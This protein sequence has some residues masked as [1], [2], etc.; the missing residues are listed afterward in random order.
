MNNKVKIFLIIISFFV[1]FIILGE[2]FGERER[3][4]LLSG[5]ILGFFLC[6]AIFTD[7]LFGLPSEVK[8]FK[9]EER[10]REKE[11]SKVRNYIWNLN[12]KDSITIDDINQLEEMA[13]NI[14]NER[15]D[16]QSILHPDF[17]N[18]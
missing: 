13:S 2:L 1:I 11:W 18:D 17:N 8:R 6:C 9:K 15:E 7:R 14:E 3:G 5:A 4:F 12:F 16:R 10:K